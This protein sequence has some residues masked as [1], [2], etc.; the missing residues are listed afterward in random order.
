M[1]MFAAYIKADKKTDIFSVQFLV[2][3]YIWIV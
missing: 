3:T 1:L 2:F